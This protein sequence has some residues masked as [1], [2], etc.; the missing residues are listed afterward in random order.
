MRERNDR[1]AWDRRE[2]ATT[3]GWAVLA[4]IVAA[5]SPHTTGMRLIPSLAG[6]AAVALAVGTLRLRHGRLLPSCPKLVVPGSVAG[7]LGAAALAFAPTFAALYD[8]YTHDVWQNGHGVLL[9]FLLVG[10]ARSRLRRVEEAGGAPEGG[11]LQGLPVALLGIAL[12]VAASGA[13]LVAVS[14]V[15]LATFATGFALLTLGPRATRALA[16][17]LVLCLFLAPLPTTLGGTLGLQRL[18]TM[19]S[20]WMLQGLGI[21]VL[22]Q[23]VAL[24]LAG[25]P[26]YLVSANCSGFSAFYGGMALAVSLAAC[27]ESARRRALLLLA[28]WPLA[29]LM[30]ALRLTVLF[31]LPDIG[32][33]RA[34]DTPLHGLSGI[35]AFWGVMGGVALL[36][37]G[38]GVREA[39]R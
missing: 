27:T 16:P 17:V 4:G 13:Q 9:P 2:L 5:L 32:G 33:L 21:P 19:G 34:A 29:L 18:S 35:A 12:A 8:E 24:T 23:G 22:R 26:S 14:V 1:T 28:P 36:A 10:L 15:G 11:S 3:L 39:L 31:A 6:G 30:N 7:G 37:D 20:E 38:R 25:S